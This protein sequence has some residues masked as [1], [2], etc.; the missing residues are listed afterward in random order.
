MK[1]P[2]IS[3]VIPAFNRSHLLRKTLLSLAKQT[4]SYKKFE[5]IVIDDGSTEFLGTT[6]NKCRKKVSYPIYY[7]KRPNTGPAKARNH[8][9]QMASSEL[10][11]LLDSDVIATPTW[12]EAGYHAMSKNEDWVAAEGKT[13]IPDKNKITPFTH[14]TEN[15]SGGTYVTCN[16][17]IKKHFCKF[18]ESYKPMYYFRED[19]DLA[20]SLLSKGYHIGLIENAKVYHPVLK[21]G[22]K[23]PFRLAQRYMHDPLLKKRYPNFYKKNLDCHSVLGV[24]IPQLRK[25]IYSLYIISFLLIPLTSYGYIYFLFMLAIVCYLHIHKIESI[26]RKALYLVPILPIA[27]FVPFVMC[28]YFI[29]GVFVYWKD[30]RA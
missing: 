10:I 7:Y 29:K 3:V 14:Q 9:A 17:F 6:I 26:S 20:F 19:S 12:L 4:L 28:F 2:I 8:G 15:K 21:G 27:F 30:L 23:T 16:F 25:K 11:A 18:Y 1:R 24:K 22:L 13:F 5:V